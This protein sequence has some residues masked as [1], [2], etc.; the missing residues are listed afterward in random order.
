MSS[1]EQCILFETWRLD[2]AK[3]YLVPSLKGQ[4]KA[5]GRYP[6]LILTV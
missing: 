1:Q 2:T 5:R 6:E 4:F 3:E